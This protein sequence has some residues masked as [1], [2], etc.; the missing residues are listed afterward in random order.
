M[1]CV[2]NLLCF[3]LWKR[4]I[5]FYLLQREPV[6]DIGKSFSGFYL[7]NFRSLCWCN[8][9]VS[10][11]YDLSMFDYF[12]PKR[13]YK[14]NWQNSQFF[15]HNFLHQNVLIPPN[16]ILPTRTKRIFTTSHQVLYYFLSVKIGSI[17]FSHL[18]TCTNPI[19]LLM[20]C[21]RH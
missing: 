11:A 12:G 5:Y 21:Y 17:F 6:T 13:S 9:H 3:L 8:K 16:H 18:L 1:F 14:K 20:P 4:Y 10:V 19:I 2:P 15:I 7:I